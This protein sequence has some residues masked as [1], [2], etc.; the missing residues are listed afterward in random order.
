MLLLSPGEAAN[1][2]EI[3]AVPP[4]KDEDTYSN[5]ELHPGCVIIDLFFSC[6]TSKLPTEPFD[7][8][9][10]NTLLCAITHTA[11]SDYG[12]IIIDIQRIGTFTTTNSNVAMATIRAIL[13]SPRGIEF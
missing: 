11:F 6:K 5:I 7:E 1:V 12:V 3:N 10:V 8:D 9:G 2:A 4:P 13:E